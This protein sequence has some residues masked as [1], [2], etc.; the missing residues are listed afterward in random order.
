MTDEPD[1]DGARCGVDGRRLTH[2]WTVCQRC[3]DNLGG[4]LTELTSR[5]RR[6]DARPTSAAGEQT[7]RPVPGSRPPLRLDVVA[8]RDPRTRPEPGSSQTPG[9]VAELAHWCGIIVAERDYRTR[10]AITVDDLAEF[11]ARHD[12]HIARAG[13]GPQLCLAVRALRNALRAAT[14][15]PNPRPSAHC[16]RF[17]DVEGTPAECGAPIFLPVDG[18]HTTAAGAPA[19]RCTG[20]AATGERHEYSGADLLRLAVMNREASAS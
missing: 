20:S 6:L 12:Q 17:V 11:L 10:P 18:A 9:I 4:D 7:R 14:G 5:Y 3:S 2:G 8:L 19:V 1:D 15:E 16:P 13:Y